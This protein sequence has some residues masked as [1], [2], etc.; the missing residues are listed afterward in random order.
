MDRQ[1]LIALETLKGFLDGHAADVHLE[2]RA[3]TKT[4]VLPTWLRIMLTDK[5]EVWNFFGSERTSDSRQTEYYT[6]E[7]PR[8]A[9]SIQ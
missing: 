9:F 1:V 6:G 8:K 7:Q 4:S 5:Q 2:R 3:K